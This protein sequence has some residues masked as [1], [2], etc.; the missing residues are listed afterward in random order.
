MSQKRI[1]P[2]Q[3]PLIKIHSLEADHSKDMI[4]SKMMGG[5]KKV[6]YKKKQAYFHHCISTKKLTTMT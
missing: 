1:A 3:P 6:P 4:P 5:D 2:S